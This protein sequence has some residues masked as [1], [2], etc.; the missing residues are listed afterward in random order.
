MSRPALL[1][2]GY[3]N[4]GRGDDGLGP[5]LV[6]KLEREFPAASAW[7]PS[8]LVAMQL[9]PEHAFELRE[10][11]A[12]ILVD[13]CREILAPCELRPVIPRHD[14]SYTTHR[15]SP[16]A[17]LAICRET[18]GTAPPCW[19]LSIRGEHFGLGEGLS[20]PARENLEQAL[21]LLKARLLQEDLSDALQAPSVPLAGGHSTP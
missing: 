10:H 11:Q 5:L 6:E 13:A 9:Q 4:P 21:A 19:L 1:L 12:A 2:L 8:F 14:H 15:L 17:L 7:H 18:L 16:G 3:G 20:A